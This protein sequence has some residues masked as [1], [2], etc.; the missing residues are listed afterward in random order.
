MI[1]AIHKI[2]PEVLFPQLIAGQRQL[3]F[4]TPQ[5]I[6]SGGGDT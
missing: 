4:F 3:W 1:I 2:R 5:P 6:L